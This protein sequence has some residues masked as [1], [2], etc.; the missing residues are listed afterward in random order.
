M[1][2]KRHNK[3]VANTGQTSVTNRSPLQS[4][5]KHVSFDRH[6]TTGYDDDYI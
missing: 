2:K 6:D 3:S 1:P 4:N 5:G